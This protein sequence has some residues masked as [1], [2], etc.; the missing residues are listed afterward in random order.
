MK[1]K[2]TQKATEFLD[3]HSVAI[4][5]GVK[6]FIALAGGIASMFIGG[7]I[8]KM[9]GIDISLGDYATP[10]EMPIKKEPTPIDYTE[11]AEK[12]IEKTLSRAMDAY[13]DSEKELAAKDIRDIAM[14]DGITTAKMTAINAL[15]EICDDV[16]YDSTRGKIGGLIKEIALSL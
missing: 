1:I 14:R 9:N 6:T 16:Y 5:D 8:L 12:A 15:S 3:K 10:G 4:S 7:M 2:F 13:Y 11:L